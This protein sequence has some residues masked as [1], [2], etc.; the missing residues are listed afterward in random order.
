MLCLQ[1]LARPARAPRLARLA[2]YGSRSGNGAGEQLPQLRRPRPPPPPA[3]QVRLQWALPGG[4]HMPFALPLHREQEHILVAFASLPQVQP[5]KP[6]GP[7]QRRPA[8]QQQ[9]HGKPSSFGSGRR[10]SR[11]SSGKSALQ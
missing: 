3:E 2:A 5:A 6:A 1:A 11:R 10:S 9:K 4:G 7:P 8:A